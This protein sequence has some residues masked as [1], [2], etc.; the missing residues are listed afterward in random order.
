MTSSSNHLSAYVTKNIGDGNARYLFGAGSFAGSNMLAMYLRKTT[1]QAYLASNPSTIDAKVYTNNISELRGYYIGNNLS[2]ALTI[3][4]NGIELTNNTSNLSDGF[5]GLPNFSI[6]IMCLQQSAGGFSN[7]DNKSL[8]MA[9]I[10]S[11]LTDT[12]AIQQSQIVTNSQNIL[13]R[14]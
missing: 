9:S 1:I 2:N 5:S 6:A 7:F 8:G 11:G 4:K 3:K 14:A 13:S 12:Q 10:G